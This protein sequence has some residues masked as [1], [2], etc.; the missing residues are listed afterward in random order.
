MIIDL[1][2]NFGEPPD[3]EHVPIHRGIHDSNFFYDPLFSYERDETL[4]IESK[5]DYLIA[6][7]VLS[8][9]II[10]DNFSVDKYYRQSRREY[11]ITRDPRLV[12]KYNK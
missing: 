8:I 5:I 4:P 9:N 11:K 7:S 3:D 12:R 1:A 2:K 6:T 10:D